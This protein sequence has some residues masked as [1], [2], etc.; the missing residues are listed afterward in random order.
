M[1]L[2]AAPMAPRGIEEQ[3]R[4]LLGVCRLRDVPIITFVNKLDREGRDTF[5]LLDEIEQSLVLDVP[6]ASGPG[7]TPLWRDDLDLRCEAPKIRFVE[8]QKSAFAMRQ[9][10]CDDIGVMDLT[11]SEGI[12]AAQL[13]ELIPHRQVVLE[14]A[15]APYKCLGIGGRLGEGQG[16]SPGLMSRHHRDTLAEDLSADRERLAGG[17]PGES[18]AGP[19]TERRATGRRVD[20]DVGVDEA[21]RPSSS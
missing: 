3:T 4:K 5:D 12:P 10:S 6:P 2:D 9:H 7:G 16:V 13:H 15:E 21:H 1:V 19:V 8:G 20:E 14:N 11:T 17:Q 18:G